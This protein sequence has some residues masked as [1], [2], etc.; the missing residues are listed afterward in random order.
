MPPAE[1][2]KPT[3]GKGLGSKSVAAFFFA[4]ALFRLVVPEVLIVFNKFGHRPLVL[5]CNVP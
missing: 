4:D 3:I 1:A 5:C 2:P